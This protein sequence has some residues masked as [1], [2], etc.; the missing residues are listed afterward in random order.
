MRKKGVEDVA[1]GKVLVSDRGNL[2]FL[3]IIIAVSS[4]NKHI[5]VSKSLCGI[6]EH[7]ARAAIFQQHPYLILC[8]E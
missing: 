2:Y 4:F 6:K 5:S 3:F 1:S 7:S 8:F